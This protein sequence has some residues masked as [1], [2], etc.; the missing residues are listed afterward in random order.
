MN[1]EPC[2]FC[3]GLDLGFQHGNEDRE[4]YSC[5][6]VC[7]TCGANGPWDYVKKEDLDL[8]S[9]QLPVVPLKLWNRRF[10]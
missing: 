2:P 3:G 7:E 10:S 1:K 8:E 6:I 9:D 5:N 4:G